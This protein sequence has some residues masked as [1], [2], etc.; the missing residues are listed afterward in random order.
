M[1]YEALTGPPFVVTFLEVWDKHAASL[2]PRELSP[3][4]PK[5]RALCRTSC[6]ATRVADPGGGN[7]IAVLKE[8]GRRR[9]AGVCAQ[10]DHNSRSLHRRERYLRALERPSFRARRAIPSLSIPGNSGMG[11]DSLA[12]YLEASVSREDGLVSKGVATNASHCLQGA[13]GLWIPLQISDVFAAS[14]CGSFKPADVRALALL[15][16][17]L[18]SQ[19]T[20]S[21]RSASRKSPT[22]CTEATRLRRARELPRASQATTLIIY[23][24][25]SRA[26]ADALLCSENC[27]DRPC[28]ALLLIALFASKRSI[29]AFPQSLLRRIQRIP[30]RSP[31]C[32]ADRRRAPTDRFLMPP[33]N[34]RRR[35]PSTI[36]ARP[37]QPFLVEQ[38]TGTSPARICAIA[39]GGD[40][41]RISLSE[42]LDARLACC[43]RSAGLGRTLAW[44]GVRST[45]VAYRLADSRRFQPLFTALA[46][47]FPRRSAHKGIEMY[48][49]R[50][51]ET[52]TATLRTRLVRHIHQR[53]RALSNARHEDDEALFAPIRRGRAGARRRLCRRAHQGHR[54]ALLLSRGA[55]L[56]AGSD[57]S[58]LGRVIELSGSR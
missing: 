21:R 45:V 54:S 43:P 10:P 14:E 42:M 50:I 31:R 32:S 29:E 12:P 4:V 47:P 57:R 18:L 26:D 40:D 11:K 34:V 36:V 51:G 20:R 44:P 8:R 28:A 22:F 35:A 41:N 23:M 39:S 58:R 7:A 27:S 9:V 19:A 6:A 46:P 16:P 48:H 33:N 56:P 53:S 3:D 37:I 17:V 2:P 1:L 38:L 24:R 15:F 5:T 55:S 49:Y 30:S 52:L 25:P 13:D